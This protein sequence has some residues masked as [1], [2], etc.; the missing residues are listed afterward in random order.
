M[1]RIKKKVD[2]IWVEEA[3]RRWKKSGKARYSL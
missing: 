2:G 3:E 1:L